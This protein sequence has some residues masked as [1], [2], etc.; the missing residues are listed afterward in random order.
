[1]KTPIFITGNAG[2][3]HQL[4]LW[5]GRQ[6]PHHKLDLV[7]IQSLDLKQVVTHK[8]MEAYRHLQQPVLVEDVSLTFHALGRLPGPLI[9]WFL[10]ALDTD[11]LCRLL[12]S[13]ADRSATAEII[14]GLY[15]GRQIHYFQGRV[16]G[17]VAERPRGTYGFG[18]NAIFIPEGSDKTYAELTDQEAEALSFRAQA[19][20]KLREFLEEHQ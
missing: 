1:M 20:A 18:W 6:L 12:A 14:Y 8:V 11:G 2:K 16:P 17:Q 19:I 13:Y 3:A 9:K 5:L 7:E 15:D 4:E 10:E